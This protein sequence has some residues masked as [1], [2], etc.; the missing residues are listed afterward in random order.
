MGSG[1]GLQRG[2]RQFTWGLKSKC[3]VNECLLGSAEATGLSG[4]CS[5]G[6]AWP[7]HH[8]SILPFVAISG[9]SSIP[10]TGPLSKVL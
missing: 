3:L 9:S 4:L 10:G 7:P 5:L 2:G 8:T 1:L 6:E